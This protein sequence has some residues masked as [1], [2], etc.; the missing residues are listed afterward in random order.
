[1]KKF[2]T[3]AVCIPSKH[4]MV[5]ISEKVAAI[6]QMIDA[7]EYF[8]INRA[9]QY[10][11]T[12]TLTALKE[13]LRDSYSV[14]SLDFQGIGNAGFSTEE[15]SVQEFCR[16]AWNRRKTGSSIPEEVEGRQETQYTVGRAV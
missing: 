5:D 14:L 10:G 7:D 1:M 9:R 2:N 8:S 3:T 16:L 4:Y 12:T 15:R 6:R 11:K 13:N